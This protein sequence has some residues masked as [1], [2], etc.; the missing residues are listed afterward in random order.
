M[1]SWYSMG[2]FTFK[3]PKRLSKYQSLSFAASSADF[4][5]PQ[6][7]PSSINFIHDDVFLMTFFWWHFY[8]GIL[9]MTVSW[10]HSNDISQVKFSWWHFPGGV[11]MIIFYWWHFPGYILMMTF[12]GGILMMIFCWWR[13]PGEIL[14]MTFSWWHSHD[15]SDLSAVSFCRYLLRRGHIRMP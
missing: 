7:R 8:G 11:L 1:S 15:F 10:W 4:C 12:P 3:N 2:N 6:A 14:M 9:L 5:G 13:F